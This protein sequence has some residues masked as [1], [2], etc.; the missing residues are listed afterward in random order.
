MTE[1]Q[2]PQGT[3]E[4]TTH[5]KSKIKFH[6]ATLRQKILISVWLV[7]GL[8]GIFIL[9]QESV[10]AVDH[11][12]RRETRIPWTAPSSVLPKSGPPNFWYDADHKQLIFVGAV[13]TNQKTELLALLPPETAEKSPEAVTTYQAAIDA[14]AFES[15]QSLSSL[16]V[17]L[18]CLGGL[19]GAMGTQLRSFTAFVGNACHTRN[20]DI[21]TW[22]PYY[23]LRP[24]T[25]FI[26]GIVVV[27]VVQA[28]F[29]TVGNG[30]PSGTLWWVA[31]AILAGYSDDEFNQKLRQITKAVFG[32]NDSAADKDP[33]ASEQNVAG[34]GNENTALRP[35]AK[36]TETAV[37]GI[38]PPADANPG[39]KA[40]V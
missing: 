7:F 27:V 8:G 37:G 19:S 4:G 18:L 11:Q 28:G 16:V 17:A 33:P 39:M 38:A 15:N 21:V 29:L 23:V 12:L 24:F 34:G 5:P 20:L 32:E 36:T 26:L 2:K 1:E 35:P 3:D 30:Q 40:V 10:T 31:V 9:W 13:D 6:P 22:W 25:G 14:L